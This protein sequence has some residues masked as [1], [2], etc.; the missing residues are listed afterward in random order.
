MFLVTPPSWR[1]SLTAF[2]CAVL[3]LLF[4]VA[5]MA[6]GRI[7]WGSKTLKPNSS[8]NAWNIELKMF[9]PRPPD[10]PTVPM[11]FTFDQQVYFERSMVDGDKLV[12]RQVPMVG[13]QPIVEGVDVGF[14]DPGSGKIESRT[15]FS[16]KIHRDHGFECGI[17]KVTVRD[18]R[19][20]QIVGQPITLTLGGE[21]EVIDRRS[22]VFTG[23]KKKE[24]KA[25]ADK[26]A[27]GTDGEKAAD[28]S[29]KTAEPAAAPPANELPPADEPA[30][31]NAGEIKEKPGGCGC[32]LAEP[33]SSKTLGLGLLLAVG[34]LAARRR[35]ATARRS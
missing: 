26:P 30:N 14:L 21:N 24:K 5:A 15:R 20:D 32:R 19:N 10:V 13:K 3:V 4:Q 11:K 7:D 2:G 25:D 27:E 28:S 35:S 34:F 16:F 6:A 31:D 1:R 9:M 18:S 17:Y 29:E 8:N 23:E 22:V 12:E 33:T